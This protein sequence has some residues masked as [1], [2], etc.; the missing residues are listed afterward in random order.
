MKKKH[1]VHILL[2]ILAVYFLAIFQLPYYIYKPG[3]ADALNPIVE[4]EDGYSSKGDMHLVT[5]SGAQATPM[6]FLLAKILPHHDV[7]PIDEVFPEG[8]TDDEYMHVQ[9]Q[10]MENSQEAS[11][12]VAYQAA[13]KQISIDYNGVYVAMVVENMPAE[14]KLKMGDR[15]I[16]VDDKKIT[17][18]DDLLD[19]I[20]TKR[21]GDTISVE[22]VRD[23]ETMTESITLKELKDLDNKP[24]IGIQLVTDRAV[25][26][27]PE[28]KF[29]SGQIGGPSAGLM[30]SLEIYDQLTKEDITK[31][32]EIAGTGEID[33]DGN[34]YRIGGIDKK[35][36]AAD[37][38]G[39]DI[40][41]APNEQ[42]KKGSNYQVALETAKEIET[43]MKIVPVDTFEDAIT[44]LEELK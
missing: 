42:G 39:V 3:S 18:A 8:I 34:V 5:V 13:D 43:D 28:V 44:Y 23:D 19:Y 36:V 35:V 14:G 10:M 16:R 21:A 30:F 15:I 33:Y 27:D 37:K 7:L 11:T 32:Y 1:I 26:V 12:V 2:V 24:G 4:V 29:S 9:L 40:F 22:F 31:G 6:Q 38:E 20:Q 25:S 41:F 17:Q